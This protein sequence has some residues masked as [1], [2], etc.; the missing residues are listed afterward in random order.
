MRRWGFRLM[1]VGGLPSP[2]AG[3]EP[4][5]G[6]RPPGGAVGRSEGRPSFDGLWRRVR[7]QRR[8]ARFSKALSRRTLH[9]RPL[10][11]KATAHL[12]SSRA[13]S[14]TV[15]M[16]PRPLLWGRVRVGGRAMPISLALKH[17]ANF[18]RPRDP[19][20]RPAPKRGAGARGLDDFWLERL[21]VNP[22]ARKGRGENPRAPAR[23]AA[24]TPCPLP[25]GE[26]AR[27]SVRATGR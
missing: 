19:P 18:S 22:V 7:G 16:G 6:L 14:C 4:A 10:S 9:P 5:P 24:R 1:T 25:Q 17:C 12:G 2:L 27:A 15:P 21:C 11:R 3:K 13:A 8:Q 23:L 26:S 20:P